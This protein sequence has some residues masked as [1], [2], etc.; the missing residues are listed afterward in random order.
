MRSRRRAS[1]RSRRALSAITQL[2]AT[3]TCEGTSPNCSN[4]TAKSGR[5]VALTTKD[6]AG[7]IKLAGEAIIAL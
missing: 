7:E 3:L 4:T 5:A 1:A 6:E 2:G